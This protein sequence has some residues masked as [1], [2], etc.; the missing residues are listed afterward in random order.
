M[1]AVRQKN[2]EK[3]VDFLLELCYDI[4]CVYKNTL[5]RRKR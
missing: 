2:F 4:S 1:R 5:L 3:T